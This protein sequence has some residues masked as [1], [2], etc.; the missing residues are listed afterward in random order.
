[1][2]GSTPELD[3]TLQAYDYLL[4]ET[5]IAQTPLV[6]RDRSRLLVVQKQAHQHKIFR[7]LVVLLQP[8]DLLV[9]MIPGLFQPASW[10]AK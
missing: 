7:D 4:P 5:F 3:Q 8:G 1:M 9:L 6:P 10:V 2:L